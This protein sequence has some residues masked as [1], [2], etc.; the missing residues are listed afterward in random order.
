MQRIRSL[1]DAFYYILTVILFC[2]IAVMV[3]CAPA[4]AAG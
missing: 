2:L 3:L 1:S 4:F